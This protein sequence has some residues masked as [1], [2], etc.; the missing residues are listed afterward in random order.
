[1][2]GFAANRAH[3]VDIGGMRQGFGSVAT[4][5]IFGEGCSSAHSKIYE[6]G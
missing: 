5:E 3:W 4:T 1:V 2:A 6:A